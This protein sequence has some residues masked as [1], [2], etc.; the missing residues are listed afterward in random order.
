DVNVNAQVAV[1]GSLTAQNLFGD[2]SPVGLN[3]QLRQVFTDPRGGGRA[4]IINFKVVGVLDTKGST[5]RV[6]RDDQIL[7]P[8]TTAQRSLTGRTTSVNSIVIKAES[9]DTM[10]ATTG[11]V[12]SI[13]LQR[14]KISDPTQA[15]FQ[16][17]NQNDTL[18]A[19]SSIT[20]TF[21]L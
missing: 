9:S 17:L 15:D 21:T 2:A 20:G 10:D 13:L 14:H 11:D 6:S 16:V 5:F 7:V 3:L 8:T 19:L 1:I 12:T 4:R 18:A